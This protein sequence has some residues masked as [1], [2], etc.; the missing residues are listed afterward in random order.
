MQVDKEILER[1]S[2]LE[3]KQYA[4]DLRAIE[5][6]DRILYERLFELPVEVRIV[7]HVGVCGDR[8]YQICNKFQGRHRSFE[9]LRHQ[10]VARLSTEF[11]PP[12]WNRLSVLFDGMYVGEPEDLLNYKQGNREGILNPIKGLGEKIAKITF[13]QF[14]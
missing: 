4:G 3:L 2:G 1:L 6:E 5:G 8:L 13:I 11:A 10:V 7:A 14:Q 12:G 9:E